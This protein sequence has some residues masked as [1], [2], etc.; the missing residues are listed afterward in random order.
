[1]NVESKEKLV[2]KDGSYSALAYIQSAD[3]QKEVSVKFNISEEYFRFK[4]FKE[5]FNSRDIEN[6]WGNDKITSLL[7][8]H[9][10]RLFDYKR[11]VCNVLVGGV[12]LTAN[13]GTEI[14]S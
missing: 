10:N 9:E 3:K 1:M 5:D 14:T 6:W 13:G 8:N 7:A 4:V 11:W 2:R 12:Q